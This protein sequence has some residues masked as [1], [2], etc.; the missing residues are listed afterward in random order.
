MDLQGKPQLRQSGG[1]GHIEARQLA[2]LSDAIDDGLPMREQGGCRFLP[3]P[4]RVE[5]RLE[6]EDEVPVFPLL[7]LENGAEEPLDQ[8]VAFL[9]AGEPEPRGSLG[10]AD[11][12]LTG[13]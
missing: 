5:E 13:A 6:R 12:P 9:K 8:G 1:F 3:G 10:I 2:D 11:Q 4:L 7:V